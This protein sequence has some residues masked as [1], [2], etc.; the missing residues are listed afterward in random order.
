MVLYN[1]PINSREFKLMLN[2]A[3]F[4]NRKEGIKKLSDILQF[5]IRN[6]NGEFQDEGIEEKKRLTWYM[7]TSRH[8]LN[9]KNSSLE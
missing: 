1:R 9:A 7:D 8:D 5:Q 4:V 3:E 2:T 6:Q